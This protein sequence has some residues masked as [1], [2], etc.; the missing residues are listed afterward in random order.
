MKCSQQD[1]I[2]A[3][4]NI[5]PANMSI[6]RSIA[7]AFLESFKDL[8]GAG[9]VALR[10]P[11]CRHIMAPASLNF[12][13]SKTNEQFAAHISG[14]K[15]IFAALPVTATEIFEQP[16]SH[17]VTIWATSDGTFREEVKDDEE[18]RVDWSYRGEYM[19]VLVFNRAGDKIER[20]IEFL[21][22]KRVEEVR[23]LMDRAKR[24]LAARKGM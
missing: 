15:E 22:S 21:D 16:D 17:Q 18:P 2:T 4:H 11:D 7:L 24:N 23:V 6:Q 12:G 13:P 10:A 20:I 5:W 1:F 8:D 14:V 3:S 9:N 19:F